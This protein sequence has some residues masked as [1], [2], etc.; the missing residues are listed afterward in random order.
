MYAELT[1][2]SVS[3]ELVSTRPSHAFNVT[4]CTPCTVSHKLRHKRNL[5]AARARR[6]T[7]QTRDPEPPD[8][9]AFPAPTGRAARAHERHSRTRHT[10]PILITVLHG[11]V[12]EVTKYQTRFAHPFSF[13]RDLVFAGRL[14]AWVALIFISRVLGAITWLPAQRRSRHRQT[15]ARRCPS[16]RGLCSLAPPAR[17]RFYSATLW[18]HVKPSEAASYT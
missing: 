11:T 10:G 17:A 16:C 5:R 2:R 13:F 14:R 8:A 3:S 12:G 1:S 7:A 6:R 15:S 18:R 4:L 9:P